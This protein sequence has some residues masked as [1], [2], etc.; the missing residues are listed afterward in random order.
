MENKNIKNPML[1]KII[2]TDHIFSDKEPFLP[3]SLFSR[4]K[5]SECMH[6]NSTGIKCCEL[7]WLKRKSYGETIGI[8]ESDHRK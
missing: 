7:K 2:C 6:K 4:P 8:L 1:L 3:I 5:Y